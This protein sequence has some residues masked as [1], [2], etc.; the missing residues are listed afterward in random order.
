[1][2]RQNRA[3]VSACWMDGGAFFLGFMVIRRSD[4]H[5][6][7]ARLP[8]QFIEPLARLDRKYIEEHATAILAAVYKVLPKCVFMPDHVISLEFLKQGHDPAEAGTLRHISMDQAARSVLV[9]RHWRSAAFA[10]DVGDVDL[11]RIGKEARL[12]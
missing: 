10:V 7:Y 6:C 3:L 5:G 12:H 8:D 2:T 4:G 1:M 11:N 9:E